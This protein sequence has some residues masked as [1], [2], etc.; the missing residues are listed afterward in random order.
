[1]G[2]APSSE[3]PKRFASAYRGVCL[4]HIA[5]DDEVAGLWA[6]RE[7]GHTDATDRGQR[8]GADRGRADGNDAGQRERGDRFELGVRELVRAVDALI[9]HVD[10]HGRLADIEP[11]V[12]GVASLALDYGVSRY[13][14]GLGLSSTIIDFR[15]FSVVRVGHEFAKLEEAFKCRFGITLGR[16]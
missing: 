2:Q 5:G 13:A 15:D 1:M 8:D 14:T 10:V 4:L 12:R 9:E 6:D 7:V 16:S 11:E 3:A